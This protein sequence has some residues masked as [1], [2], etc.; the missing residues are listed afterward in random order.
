MYCRNC[1]KPLLDGDKFCSHCGS[2]VIE[3]IT[4]SAPL[5]DSENEETEAQQITEQETSGKP[6]TI[7]PPT[8]D[9]QWDIH[10]FPDHKTKKT[11]DIDFDWGDTGMYKQ[12]PDPAEDIAFGEDFKQAEMENEAAYTVPEEDEDETAG[13]PGDTEAETE[14]DETDHAE[15]ENADTAPAPEARTDKADIIEGEALE[16]ELFAERKTARVDKFYTFHKKN[17]E[18]QRL[19]DKEYEKFK[20]GQEEDDRVFRENVQGVSTDTGEEWPEFNPVEHIQEMARAREEFF[21]DDAEAEN[22]AENAEAADSG[23]KDLQEDREVPPETDG[24]LQESERPPETVAADGKD[25]KEDAQKDHNYK[26]EEWDR[27]EAEDTKKEKKKSG[28]RPGKIIIAIL[29]ILLFA[30]AVLLGIRFLAPESIVAH[31]TDQKAQ[32]VLDFFQ[33]LL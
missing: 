30:Q 31:Y 17:E 1:G 18:F 10:S 9:F 19:L 28:G 16:K 14:P 6:V 32:V 12:I 20:Q 15:T 7:A 5:P 33:G 8:K 13:S 26:K 3:D 24:S 25:D 11:E 4:P 27:F 21:T 23:E 22:A 2:K 29:V